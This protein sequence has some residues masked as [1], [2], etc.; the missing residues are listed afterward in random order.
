MYQHGPPA[1]G[2]EPGPPEAESLLE[3]PGLGLVLDLRSPIERTTRP[4][5][6]LP[7][8]VRV[9]P[10]PVIPA[11]STGATTWPDPFGAVE[12]GR[13]YA[14]LAV[15]NADLPAE[16]VHLLAAPSRPPTLIHCIAGKDRTGIVIA[17]CSNSSARPPNRSPPTTPAPRRRCPR[18]GPATALPFPASTTP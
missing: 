11:P 3:G 13:W 18:S 17:A 5:P 7:S 2:R 15:H 12:F 14:E 10:L 16:A 8:G 9:H 4:W 1:V 6:E